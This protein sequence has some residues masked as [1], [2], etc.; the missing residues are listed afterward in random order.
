MP[1]D[2]GKFI[3]TPEHE[4]FVVLHSDVFQLAAFGNDRMGNEYKALSAV[5]TLD[6]SDMEKMKLTD[7][8]HVMVT[9]AGGSVIVAVQASKK[10]EHPGICFMLRSPWSNAIIGMDRNGLPASGVRARLQA[11]RGAVTSLGSFCTL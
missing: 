10:E 7:G 11:V 2:V 8:S 9:G 3:K 6:R 4:L 5:I 1:V